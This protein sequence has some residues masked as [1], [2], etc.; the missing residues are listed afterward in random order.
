MIL[1]RSTNVGRENFMKNFLA[2]IVTRKKPRKNLALSDKRVLAK[3]AILNLTERPETITKV[4]SRKDLKLGLR[5]TAGARAE[6]EGEGE[7]EVAVIPNKE[8]S[9]RDHHKIPVKSGIEKV[10]A[11][12]EAQT[13][14]EE[15]KDPATA[16]KTSIL[17]T[18]GRSRSREK[19]KRLSVP[20]EM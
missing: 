11:E 18:K 16:Q 19:I 2:V 20:T 1:K 4:Q 5:G 12:A 9:E 10:T 13:D 17:M 14:I 8:K 7:A 3:G 15:G 6:T